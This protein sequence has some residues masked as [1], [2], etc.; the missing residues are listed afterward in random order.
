MG[1]E[2]DTIVVNR[3]H[4]AAPFPEPPER[5][6][7]GQTMPVRGVLASANRAD[8]VE[9]FRGEAADAIHGLVDC[10]KRVGE[11]SGEDV[12]LH[13][14]SGQKLTHAGVELTAEALARGGSPAGLFE[15]ARRDDGLAQTNLDGQEAVVLT[16]EKTG[17]LGITRRVPDLPFGTAGCRLTRNVLVKCGR[18]LRDDVS[19]IYSVASAELPG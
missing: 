19:N 1:G 2:P 5:L 11:V 16:P 9:R 14:E 8:F 18:F 15:L 3:K 7:E 17:S 4:D 6:V 12:E 13:P 10:L